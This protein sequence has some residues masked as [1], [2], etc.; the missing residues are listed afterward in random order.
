MTKEKKFDGWNNAKFDG[1]FVGSSS[2]SEAIQQRQM[3]FP[4]TS[5]MDNYYFLTKHQC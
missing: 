5:S 3:R 1:V 2:T 4:A